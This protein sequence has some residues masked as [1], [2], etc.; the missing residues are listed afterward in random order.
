MLILALLFG[1]DEL[2]QWIWDFVYEKRHVVLMSSH[3]SVCAAFCAHFIFS[4]PFLILDLL[5]PRVPWIQKYR[6]RREVATFHQWTRCAGRIILKYAVGVFPLTT[7]FMFLRHTHFPERAPCFYLALKECVSCLLVFDTLFFIFHYTIHK[8]PWLYH[9]IHHIHHLNRET[10]AL[11]AQDSSI[12]ELL[13]L[14]ALAFFSAMLV[15]CHPVS[16]ILFH[17]INT[18]MAVEDH[19]A[20]DFPWG[21]HRL[22]PCFT[23]APHHLAHHQQ[24]LGNFAPYFKHWDYIFGTSLHIQDQN[25][26]GRRNTA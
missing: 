18:W 7:L 26:R 11:A 25:E 10:F 13:S 14:Q 9:N 23:G 12:S 3:W 1:N 6:I 4:A 21:L 15:G 2:L 24:F 20:Y 22:L 19:C 8:I 17:V 5:S 16:E